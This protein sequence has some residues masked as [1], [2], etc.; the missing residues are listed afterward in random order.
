VSA[1]IVSDRQHNIRFAELVSFR[2][3]I[4]ASTLPWLSVCAFFKESH[5]CMS[6]TKGLIEYTIVFTILR[7][8][9]KRNRVR[10]LIDCGLKSNTLGV[11][12]R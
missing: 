12:I 7:C 3:K 6:A 4:Q 10:C 8:F 2:D 11:D 5:D 1:L 9:Y